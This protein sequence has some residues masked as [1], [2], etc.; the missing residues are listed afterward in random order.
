[1]PLTGEDIVCFANDWTADP[2]SKHQVM[3]RLAERNRVLW[4][5]AAGM[6]RPRLGS[7]KDLARLGRKARSFLAAPR[8]RL[9][10]LW[11]YS[12]PSL[13]LPTSGFASRLNR[14]LY[15]R[16]VRRQ[17]RRLALSAAPI[18]WVYAPHVAPWLRGLPRKMLVYH[19]V[20]RW[21][22]FQ[23]YDA[24][25]MARCEAELCRTAD[26]VLASAEDLAER[27]RAYGADVH[28]V[29]HGVEH[30]HFA[31]AL[32]PGPLPVDLQ[33]I[34]EPRV[35]FFGLIHEWVDTDLIAL[36]A[37]RLPYSYVLIG[38]SNQDLRP[39]LERPNVFHLGRKPYAELPAYCRGFAAA[40]VPFR[41]S[42]LTRSVNPIKLREYAAAG[43]PVVAT[44]LPEIRRCA[45]IAAVV[46]GPAEWQDALRSAVVRGGNREE[47]LAQSARVADQ[48]WDRVC[49]RIGDLV[50]VAGFATA[51]RSIQS[52]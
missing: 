15:H 34:P 36:L 50:Q 27:C 39:L 35:G 41:V 1:V 32:V 5:E 18:S 14:L 49:E 10:A 6:R 33:S 12:P 47:R 11:S 43:L 21:S 9:P 7:A 13:P 31:S 28:Y 30:A 42:E 45:D 17:L 19:C 48:D 2:T 40:M 20:D 23:E 51:Q 44:D 25:Q 16:A 52:S 37:D 8:Q 3:R 4:I 26:L 46:T 38:D 29:P 24:D 22:A